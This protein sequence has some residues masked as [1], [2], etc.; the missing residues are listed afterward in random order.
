MNAKTALGAAVLA[1][2][3][4]LAV[5]AGLASAEETA[6]E[7]ITRYEDAGYTVNIDRVGSAPLDQCTVTGI[8]NPQETTRLEPNNGQYRWWDDDYDDRLI[9][10]V[11]R[12]ISISLN[13]SR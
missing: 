12:T 13:C 3:A 2:C 5:P 11:I 1:M 9:E 7:T 4:V 10:V 6:L 8:R